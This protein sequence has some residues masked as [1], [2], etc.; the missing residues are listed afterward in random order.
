MRESFSTDSN[1]VSQSG[2]CGKFGY[3]Q[4]RPFLETI[5]EPE[6][7]FKNEWFGL[8]VFSLRGLSCLLSKRFYKPFKYRITFP[9]KRAFY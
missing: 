2:R 4:H 7:V 8:E 9:E 1:I 3:P 6:K 5:R